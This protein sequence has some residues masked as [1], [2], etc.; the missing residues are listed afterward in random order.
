MAIIQIVSLSE[1]LRNHHYWR[2][3]V[4]KIKEDK[5]SIKGYIT[6]STSIL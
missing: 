5:K 3:E 1:E 2:D 6:Q 4:Y